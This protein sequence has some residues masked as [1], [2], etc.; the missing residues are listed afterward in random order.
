MTQKFE[1][2]YTPIAVDD[3][4]EIFSYI[5]ADNYEAAKNL[6]HKIEK[7]VCK[8]ADFPKMGAVLPE[9]DYPLTKYRYR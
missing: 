4:D 8:L 6:L 2:L 1:I 7:A 3:M 9:D 5:T